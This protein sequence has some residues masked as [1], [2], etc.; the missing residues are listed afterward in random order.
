MFSRIRQH[1]LQTR[2]RGAIALMA[3]VFLVMI[4]AFTAFTVDL[5]YLSI[6]DQEL[7]AAVDSSALAAAYE[8]KSATS[9][10]VVRDAAEELAGLNSVNGQSLAL[11]RGSDIE[12]G[13]WDETTGAFTAIPVVTDMSLTNAVRITGRLNR[14]RD[15]QVNLFFAPVL[16]QN[17]AEMESSAIAV[18]GRDDERDVMLVID[19]SGSMAD[20]NRMTYT[21]AAAAVLVE[22]L[23][24][25]DRLGLAVYSYPA[26][27]DGTEQ[28]NNLPFTRGRNRGRGN[29]GGSGGGSGGETRLTGRLESHLASNFRPVT[30][31]LGQLAPGLYASRTCI[32]GGMR[33]AIEEFVNFPRYNAYGKKVQ[34]VMVLMTDGLANETEPPGTS[35]VDSIYYYANLAKQNDIIIHG[36]TLGRGADKPPIQYCA[37]QTG[38][39][40]HHVDDGDFEGLFDVYRGIGRGNDQPRLVR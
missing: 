18:I 13:Y 17:N 10:D 3:A 20:Y 12:L 37:D 4:F 11:N 5:G 7:Q 19:C 30:V 9:P 25:N 1:C 6:V 23:G 33:I 35:P 14:A 22:E 29:N 24:D 2:R 34:Q 28:N 32:G 38:G 26:L 15:S 16:G 27:V 39:E 8:L 36:I 40:Y 21:L 31:R